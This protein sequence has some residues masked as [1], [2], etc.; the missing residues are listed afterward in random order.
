[1]L[2]ER[3]AGEPMAATLALAARQAVSAAALALHWFLSSSQMRLVMMLGFRASCW[4]FS[5]LASLDW[6]VNSVAGRPSKPPWKRMVGLQ[7]PKSTPERVVVAPLPAPTPVA[8]LVEPAAAAELV[9]LEAAALELELALALA[10]ALELDLDFLELLQLEPVEA[11]A[12]AEAARVAVEKVVA[13]AM[14]SAVAVAESVEESVEESVDESVD[15]SVE[16]SEDESDDE[17]EPDR[18]T[19]LPEESTAVKLEKPWAMAT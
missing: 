13:A 7:V 2:P 19:L 15:E 8:T 9:L 18:V 3:S 10:L 17:A 11:E 12:V 14:D 6:K 4:T 1:M 16:E 5:M